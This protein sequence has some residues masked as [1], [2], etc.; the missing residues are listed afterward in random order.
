MAPSV[1]IFSAMVFMTYVTKYYTNDSFCVSIL[2]LCKTQ[3]S[4]KRGYVHV[5]LITGFCYPQLELEHIPCG[6]RGLTVNK[7][8]FFFRLVVINC[9]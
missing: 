7:Y 1:T 6:Q 3:Q 9:I 8:G 4:Q 2:P 5:L